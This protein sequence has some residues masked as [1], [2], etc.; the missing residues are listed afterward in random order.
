MDPRVASLAPKVAESFAVAANDPK[1][2]EEFAPHKESDFSDEATKIEA[3]VTSYLV[4]ALRVLSLCA[5][6]FPTKVNELISLIIK[7]MSDCTKPSGFAPTEV[8]AET[9]M[10]S[11]GRKNDETKNVKPKD[12]KQGPPEP[13]A[14][15]TGKN[16]KSIERA[17]MPD[18]ALEERSTFLQSFDACKESASNDVAID[19]K[20]P[21]SL[22]S[23]ISVLS[24]SETDDQHKRKRTNDDMN[25]VADRI[26]KRP[27]SRD[28]AWNPHKMCAP[29]SDGGASYAAMKKY[30]S[31]SR[32][33]SSPD[34]Y[35]PFTSNRDRNMHYSYRENRFPNYYGEEQ[36]EERNREDIC[37]S[38]VLHRHKLWQRFLE[39]EPTTKCLPTDTYLVIVVVHE[40]SSNDWPFLLKKF[41]KEPLCDEG[42]KSFLSIKKIVLIPRP[43]GDNEMYYCISNLHVY[44]HGTLHLKSQQDL[45][46][47]EATKHISDVDVIEPG[48]PYENFEFG[49]RVRYRDPT[50]SS[51]SHL[52]ELIP[53]IANAMDPASTGT[54]ARKVPGI[55]HGWTVNNP[56]EYKN[57]RWNMLGSIC[58]SITNGKIS[59][60]H[61]DDKDSIVSLVCEVIQEFSPC[62]IRE[63]PFFHSDPAIRATRAY[64]ARKLRKS[65]GSTTNGSQTLLS[66]RRF[67]YYFQ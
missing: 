64:F 19:Q 33:S 8:G 46:F 60:L 13:P 5:P 10:V 42:V 30:R 50:D 39:Y 3:S 22:D 24:E 57:N 43:L 58:P 61:P 47:K 59:E 41:H 40:G 2:K 23:A 4:E 49:I 45:W 15:R 17:S 16:R 34:H 67:L 25:T 7:Q 28:R 66:G 31:N 26:P 20:K 56:N 1:A 38:V 37:F 54:T 9:T 35:G 18:K 21:G 53:S 11:A 27:K 14:N 36:L 44:Q 52:R 12:A 62:G 32:S 6:V 63:T 55:S 65:L 51:L 29:R 48:C